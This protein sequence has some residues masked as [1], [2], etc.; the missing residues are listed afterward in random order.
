MRPHIT[1]S[2]EIGSQIALYRLYPTPQVAALIGVSKRTIEGWRRD[3]RGPGGTR[4]S[5]GCPAERS[6][7]A[8]ESSS[9]SSTAENRPYTAMLIDEPAGSPAGRPEDERGFI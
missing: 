8:G 1:D 2:P 6:A 5:R 7:I 9:P 4:E 3:G